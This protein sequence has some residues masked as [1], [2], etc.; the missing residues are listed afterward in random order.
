MTG[1]QM[2]TISLTDA[3]CPVFLVYCVY[4]ASISNNNNPFNGPLSTTTWVSWYKKK[5]SHSV[6]IFVGIIQHL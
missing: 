4:N 5:Y 2:L 6:P 3:A 1:S